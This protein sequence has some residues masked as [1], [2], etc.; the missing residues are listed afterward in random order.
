MALILDKTSVTT[1]T[2]TKRAWEALRN[3]RQAFANSPAAVL[4][5]EEIFVQIDSE[6][7]QIIQDPAADILFQDLIALDVAGALGAKITTTRVRR[8]DEAVRVGVSAGLDAPKQKGNQEV[9][10][11][12]ILDHSTAFAFGYDE[13]N[14]ISDKGY[15]DLIDETASATRNIRRSL[16]R[17]FLDGGST[18][19]GKVAQY[20]GVESY[21]LRSAN[22]PAQ[23][24]KSGVDFTK[25]DG[26][27][28]LKA[29][30]GVCYELT[31]KSRVTTPRTFYVSPE[32]ARQLAMPAGADA[33]LTMNLRFL[34]EQLPEVKEIKTSS[35]L[36]GN[37]M[38]A[39]VLSKE[40]VRV[41]V[42]QPIAVTPVQRLRARDPFEWDVFA[43]AGLDIRTDAEGRT[44]VAYITK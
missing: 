28:F 30:V 12:L 32:I 43:K 5:P 19:D 15:S 11:S 14:A 42:T 29:F 4:V 20:Q 8:D 21:G 23:K 31:S 3:E 41:V 22:T 17:T 33:S 13:A 34:V 37:E 26:A 18:E 24:V 40:H 16:Q 25:L 7:K 9:R 38:V 1:S 2:D 35:E 44:G 27:E 36:S 10:H 39:V 6:V